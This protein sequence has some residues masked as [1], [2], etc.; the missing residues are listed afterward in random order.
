MS[1]I[2]KEHHNEIV[3]RLKR[4]AILSHGVWFLL[5]LIL[6][7]YPYILKVE[8]ELITEAYSVAK[9]EFDAVLAKQELL[10]ILRSKPLTVGQALDLVDVA[11][12]QKSVPIPMV[13]AVIANESEF[14]PG[15]VSRK[16][17]RGLMQNM[18]ESFRVYSKNPLLN[19][20][21]QM[22]DPALSVESGLSHLGSL[23][24]IY[25]NWKTAL[26]AY[27]GGKGNAENKALD[28]YANAVI[29]QASRYEKR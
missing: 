13:L 14:E 17:A 5:V 25:G 26:R 9:A 29:A 23:Y 20:P 28:G 11:M 19:K 24:R 21:T 7:V 2:I 15:A 18:P 4:K 8:K 16:G 22:Y 27:N 6:L 3:R 1:V 10:T 12:N